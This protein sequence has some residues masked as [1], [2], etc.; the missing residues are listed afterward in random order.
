MARYR[1]YSQEFKRQVAQQQGS[2][3]GGD[4]AARKTGLEA[5]TFAVRETQ[6]ILDSISC[7]IN[8]VR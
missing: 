3:I 5:A 2:V 1:A 4:L 6:P 8:T 7:E